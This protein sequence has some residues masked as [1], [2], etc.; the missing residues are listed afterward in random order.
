M[1]DIEF[2]MADCDTN[3]IP[4]ALKV[5]AWLFIVSGIWAA[6]G[7]FA[8]LANGNISINFSVLSFFIGLGLLRLSRAWRTWA[9]IF[10]WFELICLPIFGLALLSGAGTVTGTLFEEGQISASRTRLAYFMIIVAFFL[11]AVWQ[12]RILT[13]PDVRLL[14]L[15]GLEGRPATNTPWIAGLLAFVVLAF[16]AMVNHGLTKHRGA[17]V[18]AFGLST[19]RT[20]E[21]AMYFDRVGTELDHYLRSQ[22]FLSRST[23]P[24]NGEGPHCHY[25]AQRNIWYVRESALKNDLCVL[26][27][28]PTENMSGIH[29]EVQWEASDYFWRV[30]S[31]ESRANALQHELTEWWEQYQN[32]SPVPGF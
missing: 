12:Y 29:V 15:C 17:C 23:K 30:D 8:A 2:N 7:V 25:Q 20:L 11:V 9:L 16:L 1:Q 5:V 32:N 13:R 26:I 22:G 3:R 14:F 10:T 27:V 21:Y 4:V 28:Q 6:W 18:T 31:L 24:P 19:G